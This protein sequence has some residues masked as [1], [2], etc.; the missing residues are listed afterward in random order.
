MKLLTT[1]LIFLFFNQLIAQ[2]EAQFTQYN[3]LMQNINPAYAGSRDMLNI[4]ALH[5]QQWVGLNGAPITQ[6]VSLHT[7]LKYPSVGVG[8]SVINDKIGNLNQSAISGDFSY[9]IRFG[10]T[11]KIKL[12]DGPKLSFG[13]KGSLNML[14]ADFFNLY[15]PD[16]NDAVF[17]QNYSNKIAGN[18]GLGIYFKSKH[19]FA[20]FSIPSMLESRFD[21]TQL[22]H[23]RKRHYYTTV[24]GYFVSNRMLKIRPTILFKFTEGAPLAIDGS[25]AFI[26]YDKF[27]IAANYR[28]QESVGVYAQYQINKNFKLGYGYD[29]SSNGL[30]KH[31]FGTHEVMLSYDLMKN[32]RGTIVSPRFF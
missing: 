17:S 14:N 27:W 21:P 28:L 10:E 22:T 12:V 19:L 13:L 30:I 31:N 26:F 11:K 16:P 4:T 2:Q 18:I 20:G 29:I 23:A 25:L 32:N 5:R 6:V 15:K 8:L 24:G 1:V 3:D 7:P 9:T